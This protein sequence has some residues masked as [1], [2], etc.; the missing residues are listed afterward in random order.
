MAEIDEATLERY[1]RLEALLGE[2]NANPEARKH[3]DKAIKTVRPNVETEEDVAERYAAP[4]RAELEAQRK[5]FDDYLA[6]QSKREE[7]WKKAS[8]ERAMNDAFFKIKQ[9]NGFTDEA[10]DEIKKLMVERQNGDPWA[11]AALYNHLHPAAI[12]P[13]PSSYEPQRWSMGPK[14]ELKAMGE[15]I[16][17][18]A[19]DKIN[20]TLR[21]MRNGQVH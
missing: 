6:E 15:D 11:A 18:W 5:R 9:A 10:I 19:A 14:D 4:V 20:Q 16:E 7:E 1:R 21:D 8:E 3:L 2:A 17:G 12:E 13:I